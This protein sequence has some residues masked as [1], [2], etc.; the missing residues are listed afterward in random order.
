MLNDTGE[1]LV[2]RNGPSE[3]QSYRIIAEGDARRTP[4]NSEGAHR[5]RRGRRS[6]ELGFGWM[7][8]GRRRKS[9]AQLIVSQ[10]DYE[11]GCA[12]HLHED[13][14]GYPCGTRRSTNGRERAGLH[15]A[16]VGRRL[17]R[18]AA[19]HAVYGDHRSRRIG[20]CATLHRGGESPAEK[21][22]HGESHEKARDGG[23]DRHST[24]ISEKG[25]SA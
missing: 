11:R 23:P 24:L 5:Y 3:L 9:V 16:T 17:R 25:G 6:Q 15:V 13:V 2:P 20:H 10:R 21:A 12:T 1:I 18:I 7:P 8:Q 14:R 19:L 22:D 4:R